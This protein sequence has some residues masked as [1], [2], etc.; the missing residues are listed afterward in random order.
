ME[1]SP[2][3]LK[4]FFRQPS[5]YIR[6]PSNGNYW[7][8]NSLI[9]PANGELPVLPM[10]AVDEI[11]YRTP[12]ALYNGQAVVDVIE[13]CLP[14]VKN[15][16]YTPGTDLNS[17]LIAIRI[18]SYGHEMQLES[19]CPSCNNSST[20][21][22]DMRVV[23]DQIGKPDYEKSLQH[24][25]IEV[26]FGP[27]NFQDQNAS[28]IEQFGQQQNIR[29]ITES[30]LNDQEKIKRMNATMRE[31]T[32]LTIKALAG[33]IIAIRTPDSFVTDKQHIQEYLNNC[34][35]EVYAKIRDHVID[36]RQQTDIKPIKITC[37][38][39]KEIYEQPINLEMSSFFG[40][41]S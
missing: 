7:P 28:N 40:N 24:D 16:W 17:L 21:E 13:S 38:S 11:T 34:D 10:T 29:S 19:T 1:Q 18:A 25:P 36:L 39:C 6:L 5:I 3:P 2:N 30:D 14:N 32:K 15:A 31:I 22:L 8:E 12:D 23:L 27:M 4:R 41:A 33:N 37:D 20:Y 9:M 35:R 26:I